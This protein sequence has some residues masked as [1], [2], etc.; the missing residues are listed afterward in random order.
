MLVTHAKWVWYFQNLFLP[1]PLK[2]INPPSFLPLEN[3]Q[4]S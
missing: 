2:N 4:K 3:T 1:Q